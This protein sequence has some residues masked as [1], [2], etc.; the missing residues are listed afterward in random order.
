MEGKEQAAGGKGDGGQGGL[1]KGGKGGTVTLERKYAIKGNACQRLRQIMKGKGHETSD[2]ISNA[3]LQHAKCGMSRDVGWWFLGKMS[4]KGIG[5]RKFD[6]DTTSSSDLTWYA[7]GMSE[8]TGKECRHRI[9]EGKGFGS[10]PIQT[11]RQEWVDVCELIIGM[12]RG[13]DPVVVC[14]PMYQALRCTDLDA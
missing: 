4:A 3:C 13:I 1:G 11:T 10:D 9:V 6:N 5:K 2:E 8:G 7:K 12:N 14:D